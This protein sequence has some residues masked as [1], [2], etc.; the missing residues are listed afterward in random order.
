MR[1]GETAK[2]FRE[3][4]THGDVY[5]AFQRWV[6]VLARKVCAAMSA[7]HSAFERYFLVSVVTL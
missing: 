6:D 7:K 2:V 5:A 1:R 3:V 4:N